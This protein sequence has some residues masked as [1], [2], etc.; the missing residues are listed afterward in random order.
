VVVDW[1][2][3]ADLKALAASGLFFLNSSL[4]AITSFRA[5]DFALASLR[6]LTAFVGTMNFSYIL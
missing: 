4:L 3:W 5:C 6:N 2:F 1:C